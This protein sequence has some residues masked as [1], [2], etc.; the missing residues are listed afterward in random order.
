LP[1]LNLSG[2]RAATFPLQTLGYDVDVVNTVQFSNHTGGWSVHSYQLITRQ[3]YG[4]TNGHKTTPE[5]LAA[6][7][8]GLATNG[9]ITHSRV[10]TGYVPGAAALQ[11]VGEQIE[12]MK[13]DNPDCIYVLDRECSPVSIADHQPS[14]AMSVQASTCRQTWFLSTRTCCDWQQ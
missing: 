6:I 12:K 9:L 3:G 10:L 7:F 5:Q 13:K 2:N 14:W 1:K 11:V 4:Y 8:E